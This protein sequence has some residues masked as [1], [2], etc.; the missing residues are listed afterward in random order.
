M[1]N[2]ILYDLSSDE[3]QRLMNGVRAAISIP[4]IDSL[5]DFI[6]EGVFCYTKKLDFVDPLNAIRSKE[7]FD[8]VDKRNSIGWSA[9]SLQ[10]SFKPGKPF[11]LV[12]QRADVFAKSQQLGFPGLDENSEPNLIGSALLKHWKMKVEGDA[13]RQGVTDMRICIILK[14]EKSS[15]FAYF[16]EP[17]QLYSSDELRWQWTNEDKKGLQGLRVKDDFIVYRWYKSQ[18]QLFERFVLNENCFSWKSEPKRF[19]LNEIVDLLNQRI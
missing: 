3:K 2:T 12:I 4:I 9:K 17:L 15:H 8:V 1:M 11:E 7:L 19:G 13:V 5:E 18:K 16:E 14:N 6:W 10:C